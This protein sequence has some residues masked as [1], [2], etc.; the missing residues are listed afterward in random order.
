MFKVKKDF[1]IYL[2]EINANLYLSLAEL[3]NVL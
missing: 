3:F 2:K 1:S